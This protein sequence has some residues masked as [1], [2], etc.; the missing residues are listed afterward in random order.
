MV[1]RVSDGAEKQ[2]GFSVSPGQGGRAK[3]L[4]LL[5]GKFP[6]AGTYTMRDELC[7]TNG[8]ERSP[9]STNVL[10]PS[11]LGPRHTIT[12]TLV[13]GRAPNFFVLGEPDEGGRPGRENSLPSLYNV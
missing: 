3:W 12:A 5:E 11:I 8:A 6:Q 1:N 10:Q 13:R 7:T 9:S 4:N 2:A